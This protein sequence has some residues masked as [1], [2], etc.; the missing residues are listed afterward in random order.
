VVAGQQSSSHHGIAAGNWGL[1]QH[2][3]CADRALGKLYGYWANAHMVATTDGNSGNCAC[4]HLG[5]SKPTACSYP[6]VYQFSLAALLILSVATGNCRN[7]RTG[8]G[9]RKVLPHLED[10]GLTV[11]PYPKVLL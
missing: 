3:Q 11:T 2:G 5:R 6:F 8:T 1:T 4:Y 7:G 9:C 10:A